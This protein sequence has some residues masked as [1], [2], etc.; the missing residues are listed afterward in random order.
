MNYGQ[1]K[2][3]PVD[4]WT[5]AELERVLLTTDGIGLKTKEQALEELKKR[6]KK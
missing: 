5:Q 4:Q 1:L 3:K 2:K 6:I